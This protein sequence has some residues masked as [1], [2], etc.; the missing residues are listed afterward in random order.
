MKS[1]FVPSLIKPVGAL[2]DDD[3]KK[4]NGKIIQAFGKKGG[5]MVTLMLMLAC[6]CQCDFSDQT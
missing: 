3:W 1:D 6:L 4:K 5:L 2:D